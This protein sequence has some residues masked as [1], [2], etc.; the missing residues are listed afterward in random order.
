MSYVVMARKWR[1][2]NFESL[3]GQEHVVRTL[4]NAISG[5]R[6]SHAYLF[7][8]PRGVGKTT[9]ARLIA[10]TVNCLAL[11]DNEP[12]NTC[13]RCK[14]IN[15]H[16]ATDVIE[17]DAASNGLVDDARELREKVRYAP[18]N[19][20]YKVMIIDEVHM[21]S[22]AA[23]NALLKTLEE[24]PEH[25]I[26]ILATT[27]AHKVPATIISRC[28]RFDFR[29]IP[30]KEI[31]QRLLLIA[32]D[33]KIQ[34]S[35]ESL[36][37]IAKAADGSLRDA[38]SLF[39]QVVS[40]SG[41]ELALND[42]TTILGMVNN[43]VFITLV[44]AIAKRDTKTALLTINELVNSGTDLR[45][46][47]KDWVT[48]W[49]NLVLAKI[50]P[51]WITNLDLA[52]NMQEVIAEQTALFSREELVSLAKLAVATDDEMR[53]TQHPRILLELFI[54]RLCASQ[55]IVSLEV[56]WENLN[57]L[58]AN[59][60]KSSDKK[61]NKLALDS[62][63][64]SENKSETEVAGEPVLAVTELEETKSADELQLAKEFWP[65]IV[66]EIGENNR[67]LQALLRDVE[68]TAIT[69]E[70]VVLTCISDYHYSGINQKPAR[71]S[72]EK[73]LTHRLGRPLRLELQVLNQDISQD[74]TV[75]E[76][77]PE[78]DFS[79]IIAQEPL[80]E[81]TLEIFGGKI[82]DIIKKPL[83]GGKS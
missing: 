40:F 10:K 68:L 59:L 50:M 6:I 26:F 75:S 53:R 25:T 43:Q 54:I 19:C 47:M 35:E 24:P 16:A 34:V 60:N 11:K 2:K 13:E 57:K 18:V 79:Q 67:R 27:E 32:A 82:I 31:V 70:V 46:F 3:V 48:Y 62:N 52:N 4:K 45:Q 33:E 28:Q 77:K 37:L 78:Q 8:G 42:V 83:S 12:C 72:I 69:E 58:E 15:Q 23:F 64:T 66:A 14:E 44:T 9:T 17:I 49:H 20:K 30:L 63:S 1:P 74:S 39:D 61:D 55:R 29:R 76:D 81:K 73:Q 65:E 38:Q 36:H 71:D 5:Q 80:V 22:N 7:T 51:N 21:M 56:L 41:Q